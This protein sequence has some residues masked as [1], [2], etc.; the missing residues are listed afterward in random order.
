MGSIYCVASQTRL[1]PCDCNC[2]QPLHSTCR[3]ASVMGW[4]ISC[5]RSP[6]TRTSAALLSNLTLYDILMWCGVLLDIITLIGK[7][8]CFTSAITHEAHCSNVSQTAHELEMKRFYITQ[9]SKFVDSAQRALMWY[10]GKCKRLC[11]TRT[12]QDFIEGCCRLLSVQV[13]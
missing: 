9:M 8:S 13:D 12:T 1:L 7:G 10:F 5:I 11:C 4:V 6:S 3:T 2:E